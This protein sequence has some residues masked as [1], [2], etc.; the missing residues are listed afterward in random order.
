M[1]ERFE[2]DDGDNGGVYLLRYRLFDATEL[3]DMVYDAGLEIQCLMHRGLV[4]PPTTMTTLVAER[5]S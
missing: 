2:N 1:T 5:P 4:E 3:T